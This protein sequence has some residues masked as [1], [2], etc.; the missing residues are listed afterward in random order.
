[1]IAPGA[2]ATL[3]LDGLPDTWPPN[4]KL[5]FSTLDDYG[6]TQQHEATL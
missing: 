5:R 2:S 6:N 3:P 4:V 1:M